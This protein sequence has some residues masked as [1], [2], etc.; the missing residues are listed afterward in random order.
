M[1][2]TDIT[3]AAQQTRTIWLSGRASTSAACDIATAA[4]GNSVVCGSSLNGVA[5]G[6]GDQEEMADVDMEQNAAG[7]ARDMMMAQS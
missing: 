7:E 1:R 6:R 3:E 5:D 2:N 4:G